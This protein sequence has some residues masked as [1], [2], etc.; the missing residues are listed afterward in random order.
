MQSHPRE[1]PIVASPE[2]VKQ[3]YA[4]TT[5][6]KT[7]PEIVAY[8]KGIMRTRAG[9]IINQ[10]AVEGLKV[11]GRSP[12]VQIHITMLKNKITRNAFGSVV[13]E[14]SYAYNIFYSY[15]NDNDNTKKIDETAPVTE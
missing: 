15:D 6:Y 14:C 4:V 2:E 5:D 10:V 7:A 8:M 9:A 3:S 13:L 11:Q 1:V 12:H